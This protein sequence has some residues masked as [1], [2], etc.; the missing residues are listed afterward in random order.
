MYVP[1]P[2]GVSAI[3]GITDNLLLLLLHKSDLLLHLLYHVNDLF[4][5]YS[6][7]FVKKKQLN[8]YLRVIKY[9]F[10]WIH[11]ESFDHDSLLEARSA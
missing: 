11:I 2:T 7:S 6:Y 8:M 5:I 4:S 3:T 9:N 10:Y 1:W